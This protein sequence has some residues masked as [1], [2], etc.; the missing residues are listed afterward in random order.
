[1]VK[2]ISVCIP[3][4][5]RY[6]LLRKLLISLEDSSV[7]PSVLIIDNGQQPDA[8]SSAISGFGLDVHVI[9][10]EC[11][12]GLAAAWNQFIQGTTTQRIIS[13]DDVEFSPRSIETLLNSDADI[14][15]PEG[16]GYSCFLL[17]DSCVEKIG[18]FDED[19][20]PGFAYFEDC[21]Y[22]FRIQVYGSVKSED[23]SDHG[24][25]H[26]GSASQKVSAEPVYIQD[27]KERYV[28]AQENFF[29]KHGRLPAGLSRCA[30]VDGNF[31]VIG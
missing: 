11:R 22:S 12:I 10:T 17:R 13:N 8:L 4:L 30:I 2:S 18:H 6:D 16:I 28:M 27:Y 1:M 21:D 24:I 29:K 23:V 26:I 25:T 20:S 7:I 15:Y 3:V 19:L 5:C 31:T 9:D 14:V